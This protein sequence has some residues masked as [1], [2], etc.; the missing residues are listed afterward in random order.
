M[1][2]ELLR[3]FCQTCGQSSPAI[4]DL[5]ITSACESCGTAGTL[6]PDIVWF[7]EMPKYMDEIYSLLEQCAVFAAIGTSG[8]V[9]PAAGFVNVANQSGAD[10]IEINLEPSLVESHFTLGLYGS[11]SQQ[12]P[13]WVESILSH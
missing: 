5:Y 8:H 1:H 3:K 7:G 2:G 13:A 6:R 4:D 10:S 12:V 11:A 9:Y